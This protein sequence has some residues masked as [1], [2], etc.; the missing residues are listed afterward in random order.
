MK[1]F[2]RSAL[3]FPLLFLFVFIPALPAEGQ[4]LKPTDENTIQS[5]LDEVRL[6][7][8]TLQRSNLNAY[9][10]QLLIERLRA[11]SERVARLSRVL[12]DI[13]DEM[14]SVQ[15]NINRYSEHSK[16][17]ESLI[18]DETDLKR[19]SQLEVEQKEYKLV[20]DQARPRL[21]RLPYSD[22]RD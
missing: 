7:R 10:G 12:E 18:Q 20:L 9:R 22:A 16:A 15:V 4:N 17:I 8:E 1:S 3:H 5:L 6:L 14:A 13:R 19:K 2:K 21:E 11:Q